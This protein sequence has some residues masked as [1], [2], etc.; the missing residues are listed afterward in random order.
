[1]WDGT[2][3]IQGSA[4]VLPSVREYLITSLNPGI[5]KESE[6]KHHPGEFTDAS[7]NW[8]LCANKFKKV[9]VDHFTVSS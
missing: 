5:K 9:L 6:V 4:A 7:N 1:M 8:L 2:E 3:G